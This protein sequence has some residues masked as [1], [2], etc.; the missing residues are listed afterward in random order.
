[1][2][3]PTLI[4]SICMGISIRIH[5]GLSLGGVTTAAVHI[6][7]K[8]AFLVLFIYCL[9]LL[10]FVFFCVFVSCC[11][12]L[13]VLSTLAIISLRK[14]KLVALLKVCPC[15]HVVVGVLCALP[16]GAVG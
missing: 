7:S 15:C 1:M 9:L 10:L 5:L 13:S 4:V 14:R 2:G 6:R 12:V 11:V 16:R 3:S 8:A